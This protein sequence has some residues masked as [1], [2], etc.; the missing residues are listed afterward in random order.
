[1]RALWSDRQNCAHNV[2]QNLNVSGASLIFRHQALPNP[3]GVRAISAKFPAYPRVSPRVFSLGFEGGNALFHP[4][5]RVEEPRPTGWSF[6]PQWGPSNVVDPAEWLKHGLLNQG[7]EAL[8]FYSKNV[9]KSQPSLNSSKSAPPKFSRLTQRI[10]Q[11]FYFRSNL[12][13]QNKNI[14]KDEIT[15]EGYS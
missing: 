13:R 3:Q 12:K 5:L 11:D 7:S 1:M 6:L 10:V 2:S 4:T 15:L 14:K 9:S 8:C